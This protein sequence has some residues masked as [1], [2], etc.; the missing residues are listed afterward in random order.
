M[1][2]KKVKEFFFKNE[3]GCLR[4]GFGNEESKEYQIGSPP[5]STCSCV[6]GHRRNGSSFMVLE[7]L[8][9]LD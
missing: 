6:P 9:Q 7:L 4:L 8:C 2:D 1:D 3:T 5:D